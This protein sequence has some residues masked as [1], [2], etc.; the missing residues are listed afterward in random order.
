VAVSAPLT[1]LVVDDQALFR[2]SLED[3]LRGDGFRVVS[4]GNG[5]E[6]LEMLEETVTPCLVLL[7]LVMPVMNGVE[8]LQALERRRDI[9]Q[10]RV[11]LVSAYSVVDRV[12]LGSPRI[13]GRLHK[14]VDMGELR[15][16][17]DGQLGTGFGQPLLPN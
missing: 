17:L 14:P 1:L 15:Q 7:D 13:V 10:V 12:A 16:V 8:F 2:R 5:L 6:A 4:A 9:R 11:A 3:R